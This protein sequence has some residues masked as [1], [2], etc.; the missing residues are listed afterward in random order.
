MEHEQSM[1]LHLKCEN[2]IFVQSINVKKEN[3]LSKYDK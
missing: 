3:L 2:P 1:D